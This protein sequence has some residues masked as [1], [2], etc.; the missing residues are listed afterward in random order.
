MVAYSSIASRWL[1]RRAALWTAAAL[2]AATAAGVFGS[3]AWT[4]PPQSREL[5]ALVKAVGTDRWIEPRL[6]GGFAYGPLQSPVRSGEIATAASVDLRLAAAQIEKA[7]ADN[8]N[9]QN[10]HNV[11][12]AYLVTGAIDQSIATLE[13]ASREAPNE[14][15]T[16]SDL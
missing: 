16:L 5:R 14:V 6:A 12:V 7:L 8:R 13:D 15:S 4:R 11:G 10:L 9:A 3:L 1:R 2:A